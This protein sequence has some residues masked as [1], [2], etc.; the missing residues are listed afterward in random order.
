MRFL[1]GMCA[2]L[3]LPL[4]ASTQVTTKIHDID[5]GDHIT[6]EAARPASTPARST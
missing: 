3:T 6:D 5:H 1:L 4:W 2:L